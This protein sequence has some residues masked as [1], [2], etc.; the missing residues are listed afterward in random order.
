MPRLTVSLEEEVIEQIDALQASL[1]GWKG[2]LDGVCQDGEIADARFVEQVAR[3]IEHLGDE[4]SSAAVVR[5][6]LEYFLEAV[7]RAN[8]LAE[9]E[10]G[11]EELAKD[12]E[13]EVERET[14]W[15]LTREAAKAWADEP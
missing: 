2:L 7:R 10:R 14:M 3:A 12:P 11:Y 9:M 6:A 5:E 13:Q 4:P 1:P 15:R 8:E